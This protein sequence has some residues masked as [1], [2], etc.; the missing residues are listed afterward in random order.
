MSDR[1]TWALFALAWV[2]LVIAVWAAIWDITD[3]DVAMMALFTVALVETAGY[4]ILVAWG[5]GDG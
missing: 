1:R 3:W 2:L 4:G 5:D